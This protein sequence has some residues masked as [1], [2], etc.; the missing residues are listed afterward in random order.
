MN[1]E[2]W[3][4]NIKILEPSFKMNSIE[5]HE[6]LVIIE[7]ERLSIEEKYVLLNSLNKSYEVYLDK[8]I[9][10]DLKLYWY[11][12]FSFADEGDVFIIKIKVIK[13]FER[14]KIKQ[15]IITLRKRY[16]FN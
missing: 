15:R 4:D 2:L 1:F 11:V 12:G 3:V 7:V 5:N 9:L 14:D 10:D 6:D 16:L 13:A 8:N